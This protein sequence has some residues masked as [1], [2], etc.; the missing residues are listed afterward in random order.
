ME[1]FLYLVVIMDWYS[2]YVLSWR[3]SNTLDSGFCVEV[4]EEA[5]SVSRPEIFNSDQGVQFTSAAFTSVLEGANVR[6]SM[7]GCGAAS[8]TSWWSV[9]GAA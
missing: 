9:Y 8:T 1:G 7:D 3:L 5:L 6:I 4:L 2:R